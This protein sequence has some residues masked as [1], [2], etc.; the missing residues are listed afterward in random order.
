[1][2]NITLTLG[3]NVLATGITLVGPSNTT[4]GCTV[5]TLFWNVRL[6][7]GTVYVVEAESAMAAHADAVA[8]ENAWSSIGRQPRRVLEV[9]SA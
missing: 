2:T 4:N 8:A 9:T 6:S 3:S 5:T 1:M 7:D